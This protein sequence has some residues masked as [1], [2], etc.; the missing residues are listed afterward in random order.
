MEIDKDRPHVRPDTYQR[1]PTARPQLRKAAGPYIWGWRGLNQM[2]CSW[3]GISA[4]IDPVMR[5]VVNAESETIRPPQ[6]S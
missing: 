1:L 4:S 2:A 6:T 3:A 5:R